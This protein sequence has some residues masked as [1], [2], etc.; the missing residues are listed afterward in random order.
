[1]RQADLPERWKTKLRD[2]LTAI[3]GNYETLSAPDFPADN[4]VR[5]L[6][7]DDSKI[8]FYYAFVIEAPEYKEVAVFTEHC[9]HHLF[10]L[11]DGI[12]LTIEKQ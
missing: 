5:I 3:G 2:Y 8:E 9:G 7:E 1:M 4:V 11:S 12:T 6:F 10:Q